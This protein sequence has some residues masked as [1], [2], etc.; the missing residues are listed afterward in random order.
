MVARFIEEIAGSY[1]EEA[2]ASLL[3]HHWL[4]AGEPDSAV[5][6]LLLAADNAGRAWAKGEAVA[7]LDQAL[8]LIP[9]ADVDGRRNV[10]LRRAAMH[11]RLRRR[12]VR[13]PPVR[14][15]GRGAGSCHPVG[16]ILPGLVP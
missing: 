15:A 4:A 3:A 6:Y 1:V 14:V 12:P 7:L 13:R 16:V 5:R 2:G 9:E 11:R 10:R 8:D